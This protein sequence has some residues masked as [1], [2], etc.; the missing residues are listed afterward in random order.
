[1]WRP[2]GSGCHAEIATNATTADNSMLIRRRSMW[3]RP[4][5]RQPGQ[6]DW[7]VKETAG[8][9]GSGTVQTAANGGSKLLIF[10]RASDRGLSLSCVIRRPI[11]GLRSWPRRRA[12]G[13]RRKI[14]RS[15]RATIRS[16]WGR[17]PGPSAEIDLNRSEER[18]PRRAEGHCRYRAD[19]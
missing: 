3:R 1:M 10:V 4:R 16:H 18:V 11:T 15:T 6:L 13:A 5:D 14:T 9:V 2:C 17:I 8:M 7:R 12:D 19:K